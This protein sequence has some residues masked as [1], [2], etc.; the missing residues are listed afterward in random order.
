MVTC[1]ACGHTMIG[2]PTICE[3]CGIPLAPP[4]SH[5][6]TL[7]VRRDELEITPQKTW[8][9]AQIGES[10]TIKAHIGQALQIITLIPGLEVTLG[11]EDPA[12]K[13]NPDV[14]LT[15][16][17]AHE[18]GVSRFHAA[19][20]LKDDMVQVRDLESTN[21]S[22]LNNRRIFSNQWHIVRDRDELRLGNL[23]LKLEF[24]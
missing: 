7:V 6:H 16:Y 15:A 2:S 20:C 18:K 1:T 3:S 23:L 24:S 9:S 21:G 11:R 14:D 4:N 10:Y 5:D 12:H 8:Q 22:F 19:I 17:Q 13:R